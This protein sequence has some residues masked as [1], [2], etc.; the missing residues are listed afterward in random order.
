MPFRLLAGINI[1][2]GAMNFVVERRIRKMGSDHNSRQQS[3]RREFKLR[4]NCAPTP[5]FSF[6]AEHANQFVFAMTV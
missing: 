1:A 6:F 5:F 2:Q 4:R 3:T